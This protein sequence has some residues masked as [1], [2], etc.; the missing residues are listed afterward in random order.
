MWEKLSR[1]AFGFRTQARM[2]DWVEPLL[3][4]QALREARLQ[5]LNE[6][7]EYNREQFRLFWAMG[8]PPIDALPKACVLPVQYSVIPPPYKEPEPLKMPRPGDQKP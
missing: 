6:V 4:E 1:G 3:A 7:I 5:Y 8:Q 2:F